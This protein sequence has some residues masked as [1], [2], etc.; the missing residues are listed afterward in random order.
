[1]SPEEIRLEFFHNRKKISQ[2]GIG[3]SLDPPVT[4][5]AV[6]GV[7]D[8]LFVSTRIMHAV[9]DA[10]GRDVK[11]VFPERFLKDRREKK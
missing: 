11:Y 7:I 8:R 9:A 4:R 3:K 2:S 6:A 5:Q 10:I 1:M